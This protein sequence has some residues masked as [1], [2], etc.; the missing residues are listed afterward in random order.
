MSF[1][2][3]T[4]LIWLALVLALYYAAP[5]AK[6]WWVILAANVWFYL[7][8]DK[9][10]LLAMAVAAL[11]AWYSAL[12]IGRLQALAA[13]SIRAENHQAAPAGSSAQQR[14]EKQQKRW[15][16]L[17]ILVSLG[18]LFLVK[19]YADLAAALNRAAGLH[20][21]R[22]ENLLL[23]LGISYYSLLLI[24]YV[25]DVCRQKI[26]PEQNPLRVICF[27]SFFLSIVQGPFTRYGSLMPQIDQS[28]A[29]STARML[30]GAQR[31]AWG[32]FVKLA[33]ADRAAVIA[34]YAFR[35]PARCTGA[36]LAFA[37]CCFGIQFYTDFC[38]YSH[39]MLGA[40][41]MLGL[42]LP[43]NFRQPYFSRNVSE[44]W[45]RWHISLGAWLKEY[46][47]IPLGGNRKGRVRQAGNMLAV[48]LV[49]GLWHG[50]TLNFLFWG[51]YWFLFLLLEKNLA[52]PARPAGGESAAKRICGAVWC[53]ALMFFAAVDFHTDS[54][55]SAL[56][57]WHRMLTG[58]A[59]SDVNLGSFTAMG[60]NRM[61][62]LMLAY[63]VLLVFLVDL[64]HEKGV[65]LREVLQK[66]PLV[67]KVLCYQLAMWSM[68]MLGIFL[69]TGSGTFLYARF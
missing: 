7:S 37:M 68:V 29:F 11:T 48:W 56:T 3:V 64:A 39:M 28:G 5:P 60:V 36:Q 33:V 1:T 40:G 44:F 19:Y 55:A 25:V 23:P 21:W 14:Y 65:S 4:F 49:T 53:T 32:Y 22:A 30:R 35:D 58:F 54:F 51:V 41:E 61:G 8:M 31:M 2:T 59:L 15:A 24:S 47:Y 62:L 43:E 27:A 13:D 69:S 16:A 6:R 42:A 52:K 20:L 66:L 9:A 67:P 45:N 57:F 26:P 46:V 17:S 63:G 12:R 34:D 18:I 50:A 38:G 10:G